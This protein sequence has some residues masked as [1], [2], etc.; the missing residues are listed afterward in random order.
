MTQSDSSSNNSSKNISEADM[1]PYKTM[2]QFNEEKYGKVNHEL[3][4][5]LNH[6]IIEGCKPL[7]EVEA[8]AHRQVFYDTFSHNDVIVMPSKSMMQKAMKLNIPMFSIIEDSLKEPKKRMENKISP[9]NEAQVRKKFGGGTI[10]LFNQMNKQ[11]MLQLSQ[12]KILDKS[13]SIKVK[14]MKA[15][16]KGPDLEAQAQKFQKENQG[17]L[18]K[19]IKRM[20]SRMNIDSDSSDASH[21]PTKVQSPQDFEDE[22][23]RIF[24]QVIDK[25]AK[26]R[27]TGLS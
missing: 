11:A 17:K 1:Q 22:D 10:E 24:K 27:R 26:Q 21:C 13:R 5:D 15:S 6:A 12:K 18:K 7:S 19:K 23:Y 4:G 16:D 25:K 2:M 3:K 20:T 14:R 8:L 9:V